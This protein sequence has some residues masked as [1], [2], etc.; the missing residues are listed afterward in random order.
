MRGSN[1]IDRE[2]KELYLAASQRCREI[3]TML[4]QVEG[5][6]ERGIRDTIDAMQD[7]TDSMMGG[8]LNKLITLS[9]RMFFNIMRAATIRKSGID[10][11]E[12]TETIS[13]PD[14][15]SQGTGKKPPSRRD[16][17]QKRRD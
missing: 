9:E 5:L 12:T 17:T 6:C 2:R 1:S 3:I 15:T 8:Y 14:D 4:V 10:H 16:G 11:G 7:H 13:K